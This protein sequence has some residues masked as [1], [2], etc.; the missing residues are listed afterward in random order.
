M[1]PGEVDVETEKKWRSGGR[2]R[3]GGGGGGVDSIF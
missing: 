1:P 3:G 2:E